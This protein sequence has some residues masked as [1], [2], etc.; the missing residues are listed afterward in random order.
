L[1]KT[2]SE[3]VT[4][5]CI[6][7]VYMLSGIESI[8]YNLALLFQNSAICDLDKIGALALIF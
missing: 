3:Y 5:V 8:Y 4:D 2:G 7:V 1:K 6:L